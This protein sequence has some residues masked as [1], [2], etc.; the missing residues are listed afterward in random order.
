MLRVVA[1]CVLCVMRC[2]LRVWCVVL[3]AVRCCL[4]LFAVCC[5]LLIVVGLLLL[6]CSVTCWCLKPV[7]CCVVYGCL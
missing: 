7:V 5:S 4:W 2:L 3:G 6:V 1:R